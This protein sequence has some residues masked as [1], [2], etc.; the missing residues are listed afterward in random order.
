[1]CITLNRSILCDIGAALTTLMGEMKNI[2]LNGHSSLD[3]MTIVLANM[4]SDD[5]HVD[6]KSVLKFTRHSFA[7]RGIKFRP[8]LTNASTLQQ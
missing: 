3:N 2:R 6:F 1:M 7:K 8:N 4:L 5:G